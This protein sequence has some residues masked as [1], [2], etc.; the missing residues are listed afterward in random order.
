MALFAVLVVN[1][2]ASLI[3]PLRDKCSGEFICKLTKIPFLMQ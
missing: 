2:S 1:I 3:F